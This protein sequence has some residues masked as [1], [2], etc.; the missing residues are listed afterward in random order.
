MAI[1]IYTG[2][3][4]REEIGWH[5]FASSVMAHTT[6]AVAF[7]P[8]S[9][10][11]RDGSN[12]FTYARFLVPF[13]QKHEGWAVFADACDMVCMGDISDLWALRDPTCAVQVVKH[14]YKTKHPR[15]YVGTAMES[16][17]I[18][19]ERKNWASLM[20]INCQ[21]PAW[22]RL[23]LHDV[24]EMP[25][26]ELLQFK[27]LPDELIGD[28]PRTWNW[29]VDEFGENPEAKIVHW[30]AGIPAF[31]HYSEAPMADVWAQAAVKA[32]HAT[33]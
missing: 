17:N 2:F 7:H 32:Q 6:D 3:D 24:I 27:F 14:D 1:D 25:A 16:D 11:Q 26:R 28:L 8:L 5:A 15:K 31:P 33:R 30:T 18:D 23:P 20:L 9:G 13:V 22:R 21:H 19:Y 10:K 29:L 4:S 12:A